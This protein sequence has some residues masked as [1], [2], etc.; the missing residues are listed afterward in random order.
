MALQELWPHSLPSFPLHALPQGTP[1]LKGTGPW[2]PQ[3]AER[4]SLGP[5]H[6]TGPGLTPWLI[7]TSPDTAPPGWDQR[8]VGSIHGK[9]VGSLTTLTQARH[10]SMYA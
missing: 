2:H 3:D 5:A 9:D 10:P 4:W 1:R 7:L 8:S 6:G